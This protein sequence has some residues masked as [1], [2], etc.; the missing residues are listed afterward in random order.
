M[1]DSPSDDSRQN[2]LATIQTS[3]RTGFR[4]YAA[5]K[6][7][8]ESRRLITAFLFGWLAARMNLVALVVLSYQIGD[9]AL[10]VGGMLA[11]TLLPG[12]IFQPIAGTLVDKFPG[13]NLLVI[14]YAVLALVALSYLLL[15]PF[16]SIWLLYAIRFLSGIL[17]AIDL[18]AYE[19]RLMMLTSREKRGTANAVQAIGFEVGEISGPLLGG[20]VLAIAGVS[21][22]FVLNAMVLG[23]VSYTVWRLPHSV[24]GAQRIIEDKDVEAV[25][26]TATAGREGYR[27]LLRKPE[28]V[29]FLLLTLGSGVIAYGIMTAF[30]SKALDIGMNEGSIGVFFSAIGAGA[31]VGGVFAGMGEYSSKRALAITG[32]AASAGA[33]SI[34]VFGI[35]GTFLIAVIVLFFYGLFA[36]IEEIPGLTYFQNRLP[37]TVYGRFFST[38]MM[39]A[40]FGGFLGSL[41]VPF[42]IQ[43]YGVSFALITTS[44]PGVLLGII[45]AIRE[46]GL[47]LRRPS[48]SAASPAIIAAPLIMSS[49]DPVLPEIDGLQSDDD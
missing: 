27:W 39:A 12:T 38:C 37:E 5:M 30:V 26:E 45:L 3:L 9:G 8:P 29:T 10:G 4:R 48:A 32:L 6:D 17:S 44:I 49:D 28:V 7:A 18:T 33:A 42:L 14:T 15:I 1:T 2:A 24:P 34:M 20:A 13:K 25:E 46:G 41:L 21:T 19:V 22:I 11:V 43:R 40:M 47:Q 31:L 16:A 36:N 35:S 23:F